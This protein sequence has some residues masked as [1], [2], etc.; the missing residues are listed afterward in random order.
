[1]DNPGWVEYAT[2]PQPLRDH[3]VACLG[4]GEHRSTASFRARTLASFAFIHV[5][6]GNGWYSHRGPFGAERLVRAPALIW[7]IPGREHGYGPDSAGWDEHWTL[8]GGPAV[9]SFLKLGVFDPGNPV[10]DLDTTPAEFPSL[11][12]RLR[13]ALHTGGVAGGLQASIITQQLLLASSSGRPDVLPDDQRLLRQLRRYSHHPMTMAARARSLGVTL[14]TLREVVK[15]ST[16]MTPVDVVLEARISQAQT[17]LAE[18][19]LG[20]RV[21]SARVGYDDPAYFTRLFAA[22]VGV[23]PTVFR[24]QQSRL[25]LTGSTGTISD[26]ADTESGGDHSGDA[27]R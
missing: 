8:F 11:F 25:P 22:R 6:R 10:V 7:I 3:G 9:Q 18:T 23:P 19:S 13:S 1:M 14:E 5:S 21:I 24:E 4:A 20:V 17:L 12:S 26:Q 16:G 27:V 2:P 15:A